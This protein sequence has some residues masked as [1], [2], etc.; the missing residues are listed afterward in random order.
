MEED[1]AR[2]DFTI[3][4][5]AKDS[6][7]TIFDPFGGLQ[8]IERKTLRHITAF[9]DD[10]LKEVLRGARFSATLG[11]E[12]AE[13]TQGFDARYGEI[14]RAKSLSVERIERELSLAIAR[15]PPKLAF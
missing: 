10:P 4:A 13:E 15:P 12:I 6:T 8:D 5:I 1:L 3:N 9:R 11:F 14:R 7:G 2:Q